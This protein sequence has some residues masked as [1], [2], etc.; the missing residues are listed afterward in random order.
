MLKL[1]ER[2]RI[3][4]FSSV[5]LSQIV[6]LAHSCN[7]SVMRMTLKKNIMDEKDKDGKTIVIIPPRDTSVFLPLFK[8]VDFCD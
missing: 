8:I 3:F 1:V 7:C 2:W 6:R 4:F 5:M